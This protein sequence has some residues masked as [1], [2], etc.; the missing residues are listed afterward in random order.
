MASGCTRPPSTASRYQRA[1]WTSGSGWAS[2]SSSGS[3]IRLAS[4]LDVELEPVHGLVA[5]DAQRAVRALRRAGHLQR[6]GDLLQVAD[7]R[8]PVPLR[9]V[10]GDDDGVL[11]LRLG[12]LEHLQAVGQLLGGEVDAFV[13]RHRLR[14][15]VEEGEEALQVLGL[16]VDV[17]AL[18]RRDE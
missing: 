2:R 16:D 14:L 17:A 5:G 3:S 6:L 15:R 18:Q 13:R 9:R 11:V 7:L 12:G 10:G 4:A 8:E 1:T